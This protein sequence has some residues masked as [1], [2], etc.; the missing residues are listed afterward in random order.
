MSRLFKILLAHL[1]HFFRFGS[2][3]DPFRTGFFERALT[4]GHAAY[5]ALIEKGGSPF[6][7]KKNK[8]D[9]LEFLVEVQNKTGRPIYIVPQ[10]M[11][12]SRTPQHS[13]PTFLDIFFGTEEN[14][15]KIRRMV[16][17]F[18]NPGKVF[19]EVSDPVELG[20]FLSQSKTLPENPSARALLLRRHLI[21][22]INRHRQSITGP[23][24]KS[25]DEIK[26]EILTNDPL[27]DF[28][29]HFA[30]AR[31]IPL[32]KVRSEARGYLD[33]IAAN[34]NPSFIRFAAVCV[35]WMIE[36]MFEGVSVDSDAMTRVKSLSKK[37]PLIF[38]PCHKSHVDYLALPYVLYTHNMPTPYIV[39]GN[40]LSFWPLGPLFRMGGAFFIR[41]TFRGAVLYA[42]VFS[43]YVYKLLKEGFNIKIFIEGGRSRTGKLIMPK[44]GFLSILLNAFKNGACEDLTFIPI[45]IGY[46]RVLEESA[47]LNEIEGGQ[48]EK[49]SLI[50]V[51]KARKFLKKRYG[52]IY[53][54]L[55][56]PV[57][58]RSL[59]AEAFPF[60]SKPSQKAFNAL[61]RDLGY[62]LTCAIDAVSVVT[63]HA[64]VASAILNTPKPVFSRRR[65]CS[66][67][68]TYLSYLD[69][70]QATLAGSL[71]ID[72]QMAIENALGDYL[73]R[74]F[75]ETVSTPNEEVGPE[76][77]Y[78]VKENQRPNLEYYKNNNI[79][80]FI[81]AAFTALS[82]LEK[83]AFQFSAPDLHAS[84]AQLQDF[85]RFE[86]AFTDDRPPEYL[87]R[88][89]L[90]AFIDDAV[91][92]PHPTLP[93]TYNLTSSGFRKL[94]RFSC[95]L[96]TFFES[97][98]VALDYFETS[99]QIPNNPKD[100]LRKIQARG[101]RM[102]KLKQI[103]RKES[104]SKIYFQ[105]A[106]D[107]FLSQGIKSREDG[108]KIAHFS[109]M[110]KRYRSYL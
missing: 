108:E 85:F 18:K 27:N 96:K 64:L 29:A 52:R 25:L 60:G 43:E 84:Y 30:N 37:G 74:K 53:I 63:P 3:Q 83:D 41:R 17:L 95:F 1:D 6:G 13:I 102:Y 101:N 33:E 105:N 76:A 59:Y 73:Q 79:A 11:F 44:L 62:R 103:E 40:N 7:F 107:F 93:D 68:E 19:V 35:K 47:Y 42:R 92:M 39:A 88:K 82:I 51:I 46:D 71:L 72:T 99:P 12:F 16:T 75:I 70:Q 34:A 97:Y 98:A 57:S 65:M 9:P 54:K 94:K 87:V 36:S 8:K 100:R 67:I 38:V 14:P 45:F 106:V 21:H 81:P 89:T 77:E 109:D 49:E 24:I 56:E 2:F 91:L 26:E 31:S 28:L 23:T 22:Q 15:G 4:S 90:K 50:Q 5:V 80:F 78:Q 69:F 110:I 20:T 55:G 58:A 61:V 104:L 66:D 48:K 86:F 32:P 10:L